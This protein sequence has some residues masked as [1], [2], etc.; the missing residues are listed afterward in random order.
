MGGQA[1]SML[2]CTCLFISISQANSVDVEIIVEEDYQGEK[3]GG[4]SGECT[5]LG[6]RVG[7]SGAEARS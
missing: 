4:V 1:G 3:E 6:V 2:T 7:G 5:R